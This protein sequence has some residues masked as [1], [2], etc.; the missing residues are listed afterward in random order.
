MFVDRDEKG[1][2]IGL[3]FSRQHEGH[4]YLEHN[5][6]DIIQYQLSLC[7]KDRKRQL[8][9]KVDEFLEGKIIVGNL[10]WKI[11]AKSQ[12]NILGA[13]DDFDAILEEQKALGYIPKNSTK[14]AWSSTGL[15]SKDDL[16]AIKNAIRRRK[17]YSWQGKAAIRESNRC[18][19]D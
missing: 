6:R 2:I 9:Q 16:I 10:L 7:K 17:N 12:L 5:N 15:V 14:I 8:N 13:I 18:G 11:D 19:T 3:Y 1:N 4:E